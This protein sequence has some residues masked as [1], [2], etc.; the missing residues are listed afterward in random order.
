MAAHQGGV[1]EGGDV[2]HVQVATGG[3]GQDAQAISGDAQGG[4]RTL[5]LC[6]G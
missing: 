3:A 1:L 5:V 2:Q 4:D 6:D